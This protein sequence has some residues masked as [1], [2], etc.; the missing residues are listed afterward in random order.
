MRYYLDT[1]VLIFFLL[2]NDQ[3]STD[4]FEIINDYSNSFYVSSIV[5]KEI[6]H[7]HKRGIIKESRFKTANDI[8]SAIKKAGIEIKPL[9]EYHLI[10]YAEMIIPVHEHNDPNDHVIIAQAI[11]DQMPIVSSDHQFKHYTHQGLNF[12]FNKR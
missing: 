5:V 12:I 8:L 1:N 4:V 10:K 3:L 6:I 9:N 2:D 7:L 11:S